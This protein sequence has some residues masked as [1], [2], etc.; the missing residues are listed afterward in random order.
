MTSDPADADHRIK[1]TDAAKMRIVLARVK[2]FQQGE[3]IDITPI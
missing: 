3:A 1:A 2:P